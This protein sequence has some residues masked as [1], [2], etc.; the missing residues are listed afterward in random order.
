MKRIFSS[1]R[2]GAFTLGSLLLAG[3]L[4]SSC[5]KNDNNDNSD[6]PVAG[7]LAANLAPDVNQAAITLS[8]NTLTSGPLAFGTFTGGYLGVYTGARPVASFD[9]TTGTSLNADTTFTFEA[10]KYYSV[11]VVGTASNYQNVVVV[12]DYDALDGTSGKAYVRY[13]NAIPDAASPTV[14]IASGGTNVVNDNAAFA[15]VS[16]FTAVNVGDITVNVTNGGSVNLNRTFAVEARKVYT[17]FLQGT[18][19]G[20]GNQAAAIKYITNGTLDAT[21]AK[22]SSVSAKST[23]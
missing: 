6:T 20:T 14:T 3:T 2:I 21:T 13:I 19:A 15:N 5:N 18:A 1:F 23:N 8:G 16:N 11:F 12:D 22:Q 17:I 10:D 4:I 9:Y 7:L